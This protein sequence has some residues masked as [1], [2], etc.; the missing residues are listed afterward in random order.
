M[1]T[2]KPDPPNPCLVQCWECGRAQTV[3]LSHL[4]CECGGDV[5]VLVVNGEVQV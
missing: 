3:D 5:E 1:S 4:E 2:D